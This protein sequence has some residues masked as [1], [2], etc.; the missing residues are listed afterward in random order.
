MAMKL[1]DVEREITML[2]ADD[3]NSTVSR[4]MLL[5]GLGLYS[6]SKSNSDSLIF[7]V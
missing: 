6:S 5:V 2:A 7:S 4:T 1:T 3:D